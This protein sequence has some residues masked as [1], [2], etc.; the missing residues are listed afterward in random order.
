[1]AATPGTPASTSNGT[2]SMDPPPAMAFT[3]PA[4]APPTSSSTA[5]NQ[6]TAEEASSPTH[7][8]LPTISVTLEPE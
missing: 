3:A 5:S 2:V 6:V 1:M 8:F 7:P 4:K